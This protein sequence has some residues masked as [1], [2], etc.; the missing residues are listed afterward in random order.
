[1]RSQNE[2]SD[3]SHWTPWWG[4]VRALRAV[5]LSCWSEPQERA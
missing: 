5:I 2:I 1:M 3:L 4:L